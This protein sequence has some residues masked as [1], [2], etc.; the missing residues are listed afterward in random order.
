LDRVSDP[1]VTMSRWKRRILLQASAAA[2]LAVLAAAA[3][4]APT[5]PVSLKGTQ[6]VVH[7][8]QGSFAMHGALL[9]A[10][11]ILKFV[12]RYESDAQFVG[13]G[14]ERFT[15]CLDSNR[16]AVC[17]SGEPAGTLTFS[18]TYWAKVENGVPGAGGCV[19]PIVG[20]TKGFA[21]ARGIIF[22]KD[23]PVGRTIRTTYTGTLDLG[24]NRALS[25]R[26]SHSPC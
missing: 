21:K 12:P 13:T 2:T 24:S 23:T 19:H 3:H 15:G 6:T 5:N 18:F 14:K 25:S 16:N 9:G 10:W 17:E 11:Q 20:G 4:A 8:Q 7:E 22:M 26:S 1:E